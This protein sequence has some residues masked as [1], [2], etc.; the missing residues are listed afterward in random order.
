MKYPAT[1]LFILITHLLFG[2]IPTPTDFLGYELGE[3]FTRHARV[4]DYFEEVAETARQVSI[5]NHGETYEHRPLVVTY[6]TSPDNAAQLEAIQTTNLARTGLSEGD[7]QVFSDIAIVWLSYNVHGN[8]AVST[9]AA[10]QVLYELSSGENAQA[11]E[12]LKNTVVIIDPCINP[13]GR[14]RYV[15]WYNQKANTITN[16]QPESWEHD[17]PWPGGPHEP[18]LI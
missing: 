3:R 14:D 16:A 6:V 2:Q 13:D 8:E 1:F 17:E 9:E 12:W 10:M 11:N 4:I 5:V 7:T 15:N 18:L